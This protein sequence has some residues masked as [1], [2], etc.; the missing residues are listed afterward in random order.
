MLLRVREKLCFV[1]Y[2]GEKE[3]THV[4]DT[5]FHSSRSY[6]SLARALIFIVALDQVTFPERA[7]VLVN[8]HPN[9]VIS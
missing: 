1:P 5:L 8:L 3:I 4:L 9:M 7:T 6:A 2:R